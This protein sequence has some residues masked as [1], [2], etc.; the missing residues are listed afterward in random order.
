MLATEASSPYSLLTRS[1]PG[2]GYITASFHLN[3]D[4]YKHVCSKFFKGTAAARHTSIASRSSST[5]GY[6][7]SDKGRI[8]PLILPTSVILESAGGDETPI[9]VG[10]SS[11]V[12]SELALVSIEQEKLTGSVLMLFN[13]S[14]AALLPKEFPKGSAFTKTTKKAKNIISYLKNDDKYV[15][16]ALPCYMPIPGGVAVTVK[17]KPDEAHHD[18]MRGINASA[19]GWLNALMGNGP[20]EIDFDLAFQTKVIADRVAMGG[21]F[22]IVP[23]GMT[24]VDSPFI[25]LEIVT[26]D[27]EEDDANLAAGIAELKA[28]VS[29]ALQRLNPPPPN[30]PPNPGRQC[31]SNKHRL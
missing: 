5:G 26:A 27:M 13:A 11:N 28:E 30:D 20:G 19:H 24:F 22:P 17:G 6:T 1:K 14:D 7:I 25:E 12:A 10:T 8:R 4:G 15:I 2:S 31:S 23:K 21:I 16:G 3:S 18:H 9:Y 29:E